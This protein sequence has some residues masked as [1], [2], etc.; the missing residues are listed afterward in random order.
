MDAKERNSWLAA[1]DAQLLAGCRVD[2]FRGSGRGGQKRNVTDSAVR[3]TH[4]ASGLA[5]TNCD[6]R[7]QG[8]NKL[9]ALRHLRLR[10]AM[11]CRCAPPAPMPEPP[12]GPPPG[13]KTAA[14]ALWVALAL[15]V[16]EEV[17]GR[18]GEAAAR[19][20]LSTGRLGRELAA[21]PQLWQQANHCRASYGLPPLRQS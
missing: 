17:Q 18:V 20:G 3:L 9:L 19:L 13:R 6:T 15:D 21:D 4:L 1:A 16:L 10:L 7:S 5:V 2:C 14:Y 8:T 12:S 11:E